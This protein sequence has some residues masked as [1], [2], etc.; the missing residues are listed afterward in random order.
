MAI[1]KVLTEPDPILRKKA[2]PIASV[3]NSI[4]K[5]M[6]DMLETM[7]E[8]GGVGLAANQ[9]GELKR[10]LVIDLQKDDEELE[11]SKN[12]YP[13]YVANPEILESSKEMVEAE[14]GCLSLPGQRIMISRHEN[15]RIKYLDYNNK[16]Q[17][18]KV[19][20][21][22]ARVIQHEMDHLDGKLA[23]DYLSKL[24][25]EVAIRK[26]KKMKKLAS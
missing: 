7:Y 11:R 17:D 24:K 6:D 3:D 10:I 23:I 22:L 14:E 8:D 15:I 25:K 21:W 9:V 4:R 18:V 2:E 19:E 12:F 20:G 1:L 26:L 13:L 5:L 16:S